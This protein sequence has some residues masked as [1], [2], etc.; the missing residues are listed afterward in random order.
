MFLK[1]PSSPDLRIIKSNISA[2]LLLMMCYFGSHVMYQT[3]PL[4]LN[5]FPMLLNVVN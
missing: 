5:T 1:P 3:L 4:I 2:Y